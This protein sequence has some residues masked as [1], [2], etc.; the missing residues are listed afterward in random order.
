MSH[1]FTDTHTHTVHPQ[2]VRGDAV[3]SGTVW[4]TPLVG[5]AVSCP[6]HTCCNNVGE[7]VPQENRD[8]DDKV[9]RKLMPH[10]SVGLYA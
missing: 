3:C 7:T 6:V 2:Q 9:E 1:L 8:E 5:A 10:R 4:S